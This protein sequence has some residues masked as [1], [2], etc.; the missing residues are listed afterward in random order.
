[1]AR[2]TVEDCLDKVDNR[3]D[4]VMIASKR[5]RQLQI[6]D[7][8]SWPAALLQSTFYGL[9]T[10]TPVYQVQQVRHFIVQGLDDDGGVLGLWEIDVSI[11][12]VQRLIQFFLWY[13][14]WCDNGLW[15]D[16]GHWSV[17]RRSHTC[18]NPPE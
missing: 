18:S 6:Q 8:K 14:L 2:I 7:D 1:M 5:A 13:V 4:L 11:R 10:F 17:S 15:L 12:Q 3:F 16:H 9:K